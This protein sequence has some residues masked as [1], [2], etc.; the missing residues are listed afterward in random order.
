MSLGF[1]DV[2]VGWLWE[3]GWTSIFKSGDLGLT[4]QTFYTDEVVYVSVVYV[5]VFLVLFRSFVLW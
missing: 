2:R 4:F 5:P 3:C 1:D